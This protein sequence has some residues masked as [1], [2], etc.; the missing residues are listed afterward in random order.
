MDMKKS[1]RLFN[2][3]GLLVICGFVQTAAGQ[4]PKIEISGNY[5]IMDGDVTSFSVSINGGDLRFT[6]KF[7]WV[8][9]AGKLKSGQGTSVIKVDTAGKGGQA[10]TATVEI[11]GLPA[12]CPRTSSISAD[13]D[14]KPEATKIDEFGS[15]NEEDEMARLDNFALQLMNSPN[16][17]GWVVVYAGESGKQAAAKAVIARIRTY[18]VKTRG[19]DASRIMTLEGMKKD[20]PS[21]E[22]WLVPPGAAPPGQAPDKKKPV[23]K[24]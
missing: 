23:G 5:S 15:V 17:Q 4:C 9:S 11:G 8:I 6:P 14:K 21:R 20:N 24:Q 13:V 1:R 18:L 3:V 19:V 22:L 2:V 12:L 10:I 7:D 16:D